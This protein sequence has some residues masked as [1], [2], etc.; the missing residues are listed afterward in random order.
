MKSIV[1]HERTTTSLLI[2][3]WNRD[4]F[5]YWQSLQQKQELVHNS[6]A[7]PIE[8]I[9]LGLLAGAGAD[10]SAFDPSKN[11][12]EL[13]PREFTKT[14]NDFKEQAKQNKALH[15]IVQN[16]KNKDYVGEILI[17]DIVRRNIQSAYVEYKSKNREWHLSYAIEAISSALSI[18]FDELQLH[19]VQMFCE[20]HRK[21][22][23]SVYAK[24][25]L[26]LECS[27]KSRMQID[28]KWKDVEIYA[29]TVDEFKSKGLSIL[30]S[31]SINII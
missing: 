23:S 31:S 15:L 13:S 10:S 30:Q 2:R 1:I 9:N 12:E 28:G 19:H 16:N 25:G 21:D 22:I 26:R 4:D 11:F 29:I 7:K 20:K 27:S 8:Q 3:P 17:A 6:Q 5:S 24:I 14:L 18:C